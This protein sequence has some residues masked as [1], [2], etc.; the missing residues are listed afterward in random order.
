MK[1]LVLALFT[2]SAFAAPAP[3]GLG[4][5]VADSLFLPNELAMVFSDMVDAVHNLNDITEN[6]LTFS[7]ILLKTFTYT[8]ATTPGTSKGEVTTYT[9]GGSMTAELDFSWKHK[10]LVSSNTGTGTATISSSSITLTRT[11]GITAGAPLLTVTAF[12]FEA[13]DFSKSITWTGETKKID[14]KSLAKALAD[15]SNEI[16]ADMIKEITAALNVIYADSHSKY[17]VSQVVPVFGTKVTMNTSI[18]SASSDGDGW[19]YWLSSDC[20]AKQPAPTPITFALKDG[21]SQATINEYFLGNTA[22]A[23]AEAGAFKATLEKKGH[24]GFLLDFVVADL[25]YVVPDIMND[26]SFDT[27]YTLAC[28]VVTT[29][30]ALKVRKR[31]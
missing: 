26:Y 17:P 9:D 4:T 27:S 16:K 30:G 6:K 28:N 24:E 8:P 2:I 10:G 22:V 15:T 13:A 3:A 29:S 5:Y 12:D 1:F 11:I 23:A 25:Q 19:T 21:L 31:I 14:S 20:G 18:T 7:N